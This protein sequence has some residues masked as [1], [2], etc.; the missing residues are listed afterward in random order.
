MSEA[1]S[2]SINIVDFTLDAPSSMTAL[3]VDPTTTWNKTVQYLVGIG[4]TVSTGFIFNY[5]IKSYRSRAIGNQ[6]E[7]TVSGTSTGTLSKLKDF[8]SSYGIAISG[9]VAT[10]V[11]ADQLL[12]PH[13]MAGIDGVNYL[14]LTLPSCAIDGVCV[15]GTL[16]DTHKQP[17]FDKNGVPVKLTNGLM[18]TFFFNTNRKK[19]YVYSYYKITAEQTCMDLNKHLATMDI[20]ARVAYIKIEDRVG[21]RNR[22]VPIFDMNNNLCGIDDS[23]EKNRWFNLAY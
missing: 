4:V 12:V 23:N 8:V 7:N 22:I 20:N 11:V 21:K 18:K 19:N 10:G 1:M 14:T 9:G 3:K 16:L 15:V 5:A 17:L 13:L 2:N 6:T